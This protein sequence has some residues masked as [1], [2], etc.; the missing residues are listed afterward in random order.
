MFG[1]C[2]GGEWTQRWAIRWHATCVSGWQ[3]AR[4]LLVQVF[5][6]LCSTLEYIVLLL[7]YS[8]LQYS[9]LLVHCTTGSTAT[10]I[11]EELFLRDNSEFVALVSVTRFTVVESLTMAQTWTRAAT[12]AIAQSVRFFCDLWLAYSSNVSDPFLI[13]PTSFLVSVWLWIHFLFAQYEVLLVLH[14]VQVESLLSTI[15]A[16]SD[17]RSFAGSFTDVVRSRR[18]CVLRPVIGFKSPTWNICTSHVEGA[19]FLLALTRIIDV[20]SGETNRQTF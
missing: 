11:L 3:K 20:N 18:F 12:T 17:A 6:F 9:I 15:W 16:F 5:W 14:S 4:W 19:W 10:T 1:L 13:L 2:A 8:V 7:H